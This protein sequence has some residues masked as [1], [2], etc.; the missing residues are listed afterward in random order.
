MGR[1]G[2]YIYL[3]LC[4]RMIIFILCCST[5]TCNTWHNPIPFSNISLSLSLYLSLFSFCFYSCSS[6]YSH[7]LPLLLLLCRFL[8]LLLLVNISLIS[9]LFPRT[10][11]GD[12]RV[13]SLFKNPQSFQKSY[14]P[15]FLVFVL[16]LFNLSYHRNIAGFRFFI[17]VNDKTATSRTTWLPVSRNFCR[18]KR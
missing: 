11:S 10:A 13:C 16:R 14:S 5:R 12:F 3:Y 15:S 8:Y 9:I 4:A 17:C 1:C 7:P 6:S 18:Q 2:S